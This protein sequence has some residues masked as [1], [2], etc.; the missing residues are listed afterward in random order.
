MQGRWSPWCWE[1]PRRG[2]ALAGLAGPTRGCSGS[3]PGVA[4]PRSAAG[5][6]PGCYPFYRTDPFIFPECPHVY[7]C[8]STPSF[9]SKIVRGEFCLLGAPGLHRYKGLALS[10]KQGSQRRQPARE[11]RPSWRRC[12]ECAGQGLAASSPAWWGQH[13]LDFDLCGALSPC[14]FWSKGAVWSTRPRF[15][16]GYLGDFPVHHGLPGT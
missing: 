15:T 4:A 12:S 5:P 2:L 3:R 11:P 7:F 10:R 16:P 6:S 14:H 1:G 8:G 13:T 9:G